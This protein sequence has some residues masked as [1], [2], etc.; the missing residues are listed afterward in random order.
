MSSG[1]TFL[2]WYYDDAGTQ[3][4]PVGGDDIAR[5][6]SA[7]RLKPTDEVLKAWTDGRQTHFFRSHV[8]VALGQGDLPGPPP[9]G[10]RS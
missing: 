10:G 8:S 2:G 5:L 1:W 3:V 6:V 9:G 4:G 7:G